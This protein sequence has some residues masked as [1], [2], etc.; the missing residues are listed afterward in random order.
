MQQT[1]KKP[2]VLLI[3][4]GGTIGMVENPVTG[5]LSPLDFDHILNQV[6]ELKAFD[7]QID[8]ITFNPV[9]DSSNIDPKVWVR[10]GKI[11]KENYDAYD[12]FV[13]LHG[14][15]TMSYTASALSFMLEN[16]YK[17]VILTGSQLPIGKLRTDGKENLISSI[18]IAASTR[19]GISMVPEVCIFFQN[20]LFRGNR[21]TKF[22]SEY[23]DAFQ[24]ANYPVLAKAGIEINYNYQFIHYPVSL[25]ALKIHTKLE[26]GIAVLKLFPGINKELVKN[27]FHTK[28][29][30]AVILETYG[31]GNAP[32]ESWFIN[33]IKDAS[34]RG[35][36]FLNVTQ[37]QAGSVIMGK[38]ET[39]V[40]LL[41]IGVISGYDSTIEAAITKLMFVLGKSNDPTAIKNCM[42]KSISGE[43]SR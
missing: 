20:Q 8:T 7:Y 40:Q 39:S 5:S 15:D 11:L 36:I 35:I 6:P 30:T 1:P 10:L 12:G 26:T 42:E 31:A 27:I 4:T 24:S 18:E 9:I 17:S 21:T 16:Q 37:C 22:N 43:I 3:Y 38:Y 23:F 32:T 14:T 29:L 34:K 2:A 41:E 28:G 19:N 13:I 25:K 33:L